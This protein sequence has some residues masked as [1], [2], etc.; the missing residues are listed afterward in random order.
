MLVGVGCATQTDPYKIARYY[1]VVQRVLLTLPRITDKM[2]RIL[3]ELP[4][5]TCNLLKTVCH[6][7]NDPV[8]SNYTWYPCSKRNVDSVE[9]RNQE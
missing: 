5:D 4:D 3:E 9:M 7:F 1:Q 8:T 6:H 2:L